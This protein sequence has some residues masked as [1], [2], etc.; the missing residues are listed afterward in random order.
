MGVVEAEYRITIFWSLGMVFFWGPWK[1]G[2][3]IK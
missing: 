3:Q 1:Y 2:K